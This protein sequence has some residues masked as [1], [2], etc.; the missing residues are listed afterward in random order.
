M[1]LKNNGQDLGIL[2]LRLSIAS[3]MLVHG[4]PKLMKLFEDGPIQFADPIGLGMTVSLVMT[5]FSEVFCSFAILLGF[6]TR[7]ASLILA[8]TMVVAAFVVHGQDAWSSKEK[9]VLFLVSYI[10]LVLTGGGKYSVSK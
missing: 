4:L 7:I 5:V 9:A 8:F 3:L 1:T 2:A 6:K 10:T